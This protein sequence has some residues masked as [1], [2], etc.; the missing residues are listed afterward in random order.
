MKKILF[1]AIALVG[2]LALSV[3]LSFNPSVK[4]FWNMIPYAAFAFPDIKVE[5]SEDITESVDSD[6]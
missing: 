1:L 2:M 4:F 3:S 6:I 5:D